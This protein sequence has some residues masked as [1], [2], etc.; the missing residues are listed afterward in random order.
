[1]FQ[2]PNNLLKKL[3]ADRSITIR[4]KVTK[5]A[6]FSRSHSSELSQGQF[7]KSNPKGISITA[8]ENVSFGI[9]AAASVQQV[10]K[11]SYHRV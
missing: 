2:L 8:K 1:M 10:A 7:G 9:I 11:T 4:T 6:D 3:R 5:V